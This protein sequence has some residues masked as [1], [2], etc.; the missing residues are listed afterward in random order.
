MA[1]SNKTI[2]IGPLSLFALIAMLFL[3]TLA[4]L[5]LT[6]AT[7]SLNLAQLQSEGMNQQ[8]QAEDAAQRFV[9]LLDSRYASGAIAPGATTA[10]SGAQPNSSSAEDLVNNALSNPAASNQE[11][12]ASPVDALAKEAAAAAGNQVAAA[13]QMNGATVSAQFAC[14]SGRVLDIE[15]QLGA[16]NS[17]RI[18][19]WNMTAKVNSAEA[20]TLWS[21]M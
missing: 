6:T 11:A 7:A 19:R 17:I 21:G 15:I 3:S 12:P 14:P 13:A 5:S 20:E 1:Q 8:Y 10:P 2:R 4:V 16:G 18:V 9:A